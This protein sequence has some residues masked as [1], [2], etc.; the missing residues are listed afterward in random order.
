MLPA[1]KGA[2]TA[3]ATTAQ[4]NARRLGIA[5]VPT[6]NA[7]YQ[8]DDGVGRRHVIHPVIIARMSTE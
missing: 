4:N 3:A 6:A 8:F 5:I 2:K 7:G 1:G